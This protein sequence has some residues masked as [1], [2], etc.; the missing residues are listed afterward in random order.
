MS[1]RSHLFVD[2]PNIDGVLGS[3]LR[4]KP[5]DRERPRWDTVR[6]FFDITER[7]VFPLIGPLDDRRYAFYR[8]LRDLGFS[9]PVVKKTDVLPGNDDATDCSIIN[10]VKCIIRGGCDD[11][12]V[13]LVGHDHG[14]APTL[15]EILRRGGDVNIACFREELS[16]DLLELQYLGAR[17]VDLELDVCAFSYQLPRPKLSLYS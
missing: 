8:T 9:V 14:Y 16:P 1:A 10:S 6:D 11:L 12:E 17:I 7:P 3:I 5:R 15:C 4:R 2:G 13:T